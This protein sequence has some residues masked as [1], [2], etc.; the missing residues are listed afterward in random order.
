[1]PTPDP[2]PASSL[3]VHEDHLRA[4]GLPLVIAPATR[5]REVLPAPPASA[6]GSR[7]PP[8]GSP[9]WTGRTTT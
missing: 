5:R 3:T 4:L 8:P 6:P 1:M 7:W 9:P 2:T